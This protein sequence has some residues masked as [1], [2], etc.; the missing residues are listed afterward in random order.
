MSNYS[1][2][3][4]EINKIAIKYSKQFSNNNEAEFV[5]IF[6]GI[7]TSDYPTPKGFY[8][9]KFERYYKGKPIIIKIP[10]FEVH[11]LKFYKTGNNSFSDYESFTTSLIEVSE[12]ANTANLFEECDRRDVIL[13][14]WSATILG[15]LG[16]KT[17]I[18]VKSLSQTVNQIYEL[19]YSYNK[20]FACR[21]SEIEQSDN[22]PEFII[23]MVK[24]IN[25]KRNTWSNTILTGYQ[26]RFYFTDGYKRAKLFNKENKYKELIK[27]LFTPKEA[28][29]LSLKYNIVS[30]TVCQLISEYF[31]QSEQN[32]QFLHKGK[33]LTKVD[34]MN[35]ISESQL[36]N[37][38]YYALYH[39]VLIKLGI[40]NP[41]PI[42]FE[43]GRKNQIE[44]IA[45]AKYSNISSQQFYNL[46]KDL[47]IANKKTLI[48]SY[49]NNYKNFIEKIP[50]YNKAV[51]DYL[52][53]LPE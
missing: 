41:L 29:H 11:N 9:F 48:Q 19:I 15:A 20:W 13:P 32:I 22:K 44:L 12:W 46:I 24:E 52:D 38:K 37:A 51:I 10:Y 17:L 30:K 16:D 45:N 2:R 49:G 50:N 7:F 14:D 21:L 18:D 5:K 28:T 33:D 31:P 8:Y 40:E 34:K 6:S 3:L 4:E 53:N 43:K 1:F 27:Y 36:N 26:F 39:W 42:A 35:N 47:N 23:N 25:E